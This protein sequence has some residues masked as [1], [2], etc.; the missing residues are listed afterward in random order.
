M[1]RAKVASLA[2]IISVLVW[3][4]AG[5]S[6]MPA[7][8]GG[9]LIY[10]LTLAPSGIDPHVNASSE[11]GIPLTS[12]YD[13]LVWQDL[14]GEFVPGLA[15]SWEVSDDGLTYTFH[16]RRNVRF[17]DGTPFNAQAVKFNL[18]RVVDPQTKSQ[19]AVFMLGPYD[20]AEVVDDYTIKVY[21]QEPS[22]PLLDSLSQVYLGMASPAAV[23]KWG[24]DYQMH[25]VGTGPFMFKEYI[26]KDHLTLVR[27]P[28]YNWAPTIFGHQGPAY[29]EEIEFRFFVE[30]ATRSLALES[31]E[32]H[33]MGEIPPQDAQ[34]LSQDP[35]FQLIPVALPGT[36]LML[37]VNTARP[38]TDDL[39]VRQALIYATDREAIVAAIFKNL[40]PVAYGPLT[41]VTLG[42]DENVVGLYDHDPEL[43]KDLL[44]QAGWVDANGDGVLEKDG[45]PLRVEAYLMSWGFMPEVAQ[46]LQAQFKAVGVEMQS[47][48]VAYPA[49]LEA[50]REGKHNLIPFSLS[51]SDP[52]ILRTFFHSEGGFN[53]AK[54]RDPRLDELLEEGARTLDLE[55]RKALYAEAQRI[56]MAEALII[57]IRDYVNLNAAQGQVKG[58]R[59]DLRGW[60]PWLY[61]VY[62]AGGRSD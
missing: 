22:A 46:L 25:Q 12:V 41:A 32:A 60:F 27:N 51:S 6:S 49:A 40:S 30:P 50:A 2:V 33:V 35:D 18:D 42:Y 3:I 28:D 7:P 54:V 9:K 59:Y 17:H 20:H 37:F 34:R 31:G 10:G 62:L 26:P 56:I 11:L 48:V 8:Q 47:Q 14:D 45:Q 44:Q 4:L 13:T 5:C 16:L 57:P 29:L 39:K 61:D 36:P 38:P 55:K 23:E 52:D 58:L 19:K 15:E 24:L 53:W 1:K 43:A 21:L